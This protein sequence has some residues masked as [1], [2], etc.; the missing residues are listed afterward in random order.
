VDV[1]IDPAQP[2]RAESW[3]HVTTAELG[4]N[5]VLAAYAE[6]R[7][8]IWFSVQGVG[9]MRWDINGLVAGPDDPLTWRTTGDDDWNTAPIADPGGGSVEFTAVNAITVDAAGD[10]W[11]GGSGLARFSYAPSLDLVTFGA[12][13]QLKADT[14][15]PGLL[16]QV[17]QGLAFDRNEDLWILSDSGLNRFRLG[18]SGLAVDAFTDLVTFGGL[19]QRFYSAAA[20]APLP[21]GTYRDMDMATDGTRLVL[22]SDLGAVMVDV[23]DRVAVGGDAVDQSYLYPNPFPGDD[24]GTSLSLG[25]LVI[26]E[27]RP[28][29]VEVLNL[30]GQIVF[31][32]SRVESAVGIWDGRNRLGERV[33]SGLYV[34][35]ISQGD[36]SRL[37]TLAVAY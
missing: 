4:G 36:R 3:H 2:F 5:V 23:P 33:A 29:V 11:A 22:T 26:D 1:L 7:D 19:D 32:N 8:V 25:G 28:A 13:W 16:G 9:L 21:G 17:V 14:F 24:G 18:G 31:R 20:I 15:T 10:I 27:D 12:E 35:K 30:A 37:R 6:R 34:V